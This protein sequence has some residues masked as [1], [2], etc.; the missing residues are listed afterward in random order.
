MIFLLIEVIKHR[1][2]NNRH[3]LAHRLESLAI[4]FEIF[5]NSDGGCKPVCRAAR[6][7]DG[8]DFLH[9][10]L[11]VKKVGFSL[12]GCTSSAIHASDRSVF[13]K[14]YAYA[15]KLVLIVSY[16]KT[17]RY[18]Y[19]HFHTS[20]KSSEQEGLSFFYLHKSSMLVCS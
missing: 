18:C 4:L 17:G 15:R 6:Q 12:T 13:G 14:D 20:K 2:A 5:H 16:L 9:H 7:H 8:I 10:L 19:I 1:T 3:D 11:V